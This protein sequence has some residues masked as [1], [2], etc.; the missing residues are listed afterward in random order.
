MRREA[1]KAVEDGD[2]VLGGIYAG[3]SRRFVIGR[4]Q[5]LFDCF[6][7]TIRSSTDRYA[8]HTVVSLLSITSVKDLFYEVVVDSTDAIELKD[9]ILLGPQQH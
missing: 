4:V 6:I 3:F 9:C 7:C 2:K 8:G 5:R 1:F